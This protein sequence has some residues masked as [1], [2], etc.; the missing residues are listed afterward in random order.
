MKKIIIMMLI[1]LSTLSLIGCKD[2]SEELIRKLDEL[3]VKSRTRA[4]FM[5]FVDLLGTDNMSIFCYENMEITYH[6]E[7]NGITVIVYNVNPNEN[8]EL[9]IISYS[10][11][12]LDNSTKEIP[13]N[14]DN[15]D[16]LEDKECGFKWKIN[17][18]TR[19]KNIDIYL[20]FWTLCDENE[21]IVDNKILHV[22]N[23]QN[24]YIHTFVYWVYKYEK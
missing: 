5:E 6:E 13:I 17:L 4:S 22:I 15:F 18:E 21:R 3:V 9:P 19:K 12:L 1:L 2:S 20:S 10:K 24:D 16:L 14:T 11:W 23:S 7:L 8:V